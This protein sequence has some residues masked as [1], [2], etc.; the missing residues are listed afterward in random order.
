LFFH[1]TLELARLDRAAERSDEII[2]IVS[3]FV[4]IFFYAVF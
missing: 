2:E 1:L 4:L 3:F